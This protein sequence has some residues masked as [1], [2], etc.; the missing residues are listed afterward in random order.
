MKFLAPPISRCIQ[1]SCLQSSAALTIHNNPV[2]VVVFTLTGP[3]PATKLSFTQRCHR[4]LT[5]YNYS[6]HGNKGKN[7]E[8]FYAEHERPLV[9]VS[10]SVF[11]ERKLCQLFRS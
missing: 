5:N 9:E 11:V 3:V 1:P 7:G 10:D 6:M 8:R 4:C 2:D